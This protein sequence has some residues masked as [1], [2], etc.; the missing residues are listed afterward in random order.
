M[1]L[2]PTFLLFLVAILLPLPSFAQQIPLSFEE[3]TSLILS[4][5]RSLTYLQQEL[6][7]SKL[8]QSLKTSSPPELR[9]SNLENM[10]LK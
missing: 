7:V 9:L 4:Q 2:H 8:R 1:S 5:D 10:I 6:E 3:A